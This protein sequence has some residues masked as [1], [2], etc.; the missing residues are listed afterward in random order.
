MRLSPQT[1]PP[2]PLFEVE[3]LM[4]DLPDNTVLFV[5]S[6]HGHERAAAAAAPPTTRARRGCGSSRRPWS[7]KVKTATAKVDPHR[8]ARRPAHRPRAPLR[9][10]YAQGAHRRS[11]PP[12][13]AAASTA[14]P[15]AADARV[16]PPPGVLG[17][18]PPRPTSSR[19]ARCSTAVPRP[20]T[21]RSGW[22]TS[23]R[24]SRS[25]AGCR[26]ATPRARSSPRCS[27]R[28]RRR[29]GCATPTTDPEVVRRAHDLAVEQLDEDRLRP[30]A[31]G[32]GRAGARRRR[33]T[34]R[35][36]RGSGSRRRTGAK[37]TDDAKAAAVRGRA[38]Q[39]RVTFVVAGLLVV[40]VF[41]VLHTVTFA[42]PWYILRYRAYAKE[43]G[44]RSGRCP[45][46]WRW[47]GPSAS[48]LPTCSP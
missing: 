42:D 17:I 23:R 35:R 9:S 31:D 14:R 18:S 13:S 36:R 27:G 30:L 19:A 16:A 43:A 32:A 12:P 1:L 11:L 20:P 39:L 10:L 26:R 29:G 34:R 15:P 4:R 44:Q 48:S 47:R 28:C 2:Y 22:S 24:R 40:M 46:W 37:V 25:S 21:A 3:T 8:P 6:D 41:W 5:L 7:T 38:A 33:R 45:T